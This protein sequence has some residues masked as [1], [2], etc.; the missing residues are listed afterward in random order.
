[1]KP[2]KISEGIYR[3]GANIENG[4]LFE[5]LWPIPDGVSLNSYILKG[6]KTALIDLVRDWDNAPGKVLDQIRSI[7]LEVEDLDYLIMNHMEPDHTG[8][9]AEFV[10]L[11]PKL[12]IITSV[13]AVPLVKEF[14]GITENVRAVK[15]GDTLSLGNNIDLIFED[16]PN[17]HWPETMV[18][19][20]KNSGV[21]FACDAFGSYGSLGDAIFDD[22]L[23]DEDHAFFEKEA[24]RYYANIVA[25]FS[26][27]VERAIKKLG[28]L[29]INVI[30]P[31][32]GIIWREN[33]ERIIE[34]YIKYA[35]YMNGP[36]EPEITIIWG[37]MYGNTKTALT[38]II[39]GIRSENIPVHMVQI[40][41]EDVSY[42]LGY[43]WKSA[44]IVLGMPTYEYKMFPPMAY[45]LDVFAR[46]HVW[47]KKVLRFGSFGWSGGAE[48]EYQEKITSLK[49]DCIDPLE[50]QGAPSEQDLET[51]YEKGR[52]LARQ[53]KEY[54]GVS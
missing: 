40:P 46:K 27:F 12:E 6:E 23:S 51:A 24:L 20:E 48:K 37:S 49:W 36:A 14:Y 29:K 54:C 8:W 33:P 21:L 26:V 10:K 34:R 9:L 35:G 41:N 2:Q 1:M 3:I 15:S 5:G 52:E 13:K 32:H 25:S 38:S 22:Q 50:W 11:C 4:D 43:A 7:P 16:V 18:T 28:G 44:G 47:N 19:Y 39:K 45:V 30:A 53:V 42:A 31:S 17:V